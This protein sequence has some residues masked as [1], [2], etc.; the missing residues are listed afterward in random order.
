V[1]PNERRD[2]PPERGKP[3]FLAQQIKIVCI[4]LI[5]VGDHTVDCPKKKSEI[6]IGNMRSDCIGIPEKFWCQHE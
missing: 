2:L 4:V 1:L 3:E 6:R 5:D